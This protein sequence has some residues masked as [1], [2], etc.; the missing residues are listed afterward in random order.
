M[1]KKMDICG[2]DDGY[3]GRDDVSTSRSNLPGKTVTE[4]EISQILL[5]KTYFPRH[6]AES[7]IHHIFTQMD[8]YSHANE[9][10]KKGKIEKQEK[11]Q[12]QDFYS[13]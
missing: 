8:F 6:L 2:D 10:R 12:C 13:T 5:R 7:D 9:R 1:A 4:K 3:Q 11:Y